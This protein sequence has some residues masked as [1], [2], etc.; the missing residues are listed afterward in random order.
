MRAFF[1][2]FCL[3]LSMSSA[4]ADEE[5]MAF[6]AFTDE[7]L[8]EAKVLYPDLI[9]KKIAPDAISYQQPNLPSEDENIGTIYTGNVHRNYVYDPESK[10]QIINNFLSAMP[11]DGEID[12]SNARNR[13]V[14]VLR[15]SDYLE[16][17]PE[18]LKNGLI[19]RPFAINVM[20][21][22]MLDSPT[23]LS[24]ASA[25]LLAENDLTESEAFILAEANTRRLMGEIYEE[26]IDG[27]TMLSSENGLITA[28]PW[29]PENCTS[30]T[31][32]YVAYMPERDYLLKA[33]IT[34]DGLGFQMIFSYAGELILAGESFAN[35]VLICDGGEWT[36]GI[37]RLDGAE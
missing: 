10:D 17:A 8:T 1:L 13:F 21:V 11:L 22:L 24:T 28:Y 14:V 2:S 26:D 16:G 30:E 25:E 34:E 15:P 7:V 29:L 3:W 6:E 5:L 9:F 27:I 19:W 12:T 35:G 4:L 31:Q 36:H 18:D 33:P 32:S 23:A 37:P 20:A